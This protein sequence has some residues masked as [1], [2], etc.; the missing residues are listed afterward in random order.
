M[1]WTQLWAGAQ[2]LHAAEAVSVFWP[3][4]GF[5]VALQ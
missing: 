1:E 2:G 4:L 5:V 3:C